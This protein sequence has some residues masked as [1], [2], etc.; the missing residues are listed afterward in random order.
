MNL[1]NTIVLCGIQLKNEFR[2]YNSGIRC[3]IYNYIK[4][5]IVTNYFNFNIL[6]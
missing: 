3:K 2:R 6:K 5:Y 1:D 4:Y